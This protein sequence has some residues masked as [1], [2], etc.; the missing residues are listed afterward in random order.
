MLFGMHC[1]TR[2]S[3]LEIID[4]TLYAKLVLSHARRDADLLTI[5]YIIALLALQISAERFNI[6]RLQINQVFICA[7]PTH[8]V[9]NANMWLR[10][11]AMNSK[12]FSFLD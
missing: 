5:I 1:C 10:E 11:N 9:L 4:V 2:T 12:V 6:F 3:T 7:T 8:S